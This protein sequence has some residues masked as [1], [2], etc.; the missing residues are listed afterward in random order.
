MLL[1]TDLI[2]SLQGGETPAA[3]A[4]VKI[5]QNQSHVDKVTNICKVWRNRADYAEAYEQASLGVEREAGLGNLGLN[6]EALSSVET[7]PFVEQLL[8]LQA[9]RCVL[10]GKPD[11]ALELTTTR[12]N[13][14]W[15]L[16]GHANQ[17]RWALLDD[18]AQI[19]NLC[20]RIIADLKTV[21]KSPTAM[22]QTYVEHDS[23][24]YILD[25][26]YRH[27]ETKYSTFDLELG[28][29]HRTL[30]QVVALIRQKYSQT[31]ERCIEAFTDA[32]QDADFQIEGHPSQDTIFQRYVQPG[33]GKPGKTAYVLVDALRYEMGRELMDGL[34]EEFEVTIEP[35]IALLPSTTPVGMAAL[36]P[37]V[38]KGLELVEMPGGKIAITVGS[39]TLKDRASRV[40]HFCQA[41]GS[42]ATVL[43]FTQTL[44]WFEMMHIEYNIGVDAISV[45]MK[46]GRASCRERV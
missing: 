32:L 28:R 40:K 21:E 18:A 16:R 8:L 17:L 29:E 3:F 25:T 9:E 12:R 35:S 37:G 27:L 43:H 11:K 10:D 31:V 7:F 46:I 41:V 19:L 6:P 33:A 42:D 34:S 24:W 22:V 1:L 13:S 5:P 4:S 45:L 44:P 14:F 23:P 26:H 36:M 2:A 20:S 30:E 39:S 15:S 38:E